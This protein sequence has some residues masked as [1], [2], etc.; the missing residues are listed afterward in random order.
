[1][2]RPEQ[3]KIW[4]NFLFPL[5]CIVYQHH[6]STKPPLTAEPCSTM[7]SNLLLASTREPFKD[8]ILSCI[9][10]TFFLVRGH[11]DPPLCTCTS[12]LCKL[13]IIGYLMYIQPSISKNLYNNALTTNG[14]NSYQRFLRGCS[15][16]IILNLVQI[17]FS[18][19]FLDWL[20]FIFID[21]TNE[22]H[23][24]I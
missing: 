5:L 15:Q 2:A 24:F 4:K 22:F 19:S 16:V 10:I 23:L 9:K 18:I 6:E 3:F 12:G 8:N 21:I 7:K 17:K 20:I 11:H 14:W 1:M 13:S